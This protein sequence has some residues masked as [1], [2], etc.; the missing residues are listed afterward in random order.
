[1]SIDK[2]FARAALLALPL[3]LAAPAQAS[4]V[5]IIDND[6]PY[7][8]S[9]TLHDGILGPGTGADFVAGQIVLTTNSGTLYSW[10]VDILHWINFGHSYDYQTGSLV[11]NN[12]GETDADSGL[13]SALQIQQIGAVAAYGNSLMNATPSSDLSAAV[14]AA[15]W[16]IEYGTTATG[17]AGME[18]D[19][20]GIMAHLATLP[21][22]SGYQLNYVSG[23][24]GLT[25][26]ELYATQGEHRTQALFISAVP[27]PAAWAMLIAGFGMLGFAMR[28]ARKG[29]V[30]AI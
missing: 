9:V 23:P 26:D 25:S 7:R 24:D 11:S 17:T 2:G 20:A 6:A 28:Y 27:E 4:T 16:N 22:A 5:T 19:L 18:S 12:T 13:L 21:A 3:A 8:E 29:A 10:C 15:I 30:A 14:Q 1:M